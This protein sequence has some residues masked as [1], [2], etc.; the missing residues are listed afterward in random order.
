MS[1]SNVIDEKS[2]GTD[3]ENLNIKSQD[4]DT[5]QKRKRE[6]V[7]SVSSVLDSSSVS[8]KE[9]ENRDSKGRKSKKT[10]KRKRTSRQEDI[11]TN[12]KTT[13]M[14]SK[15]GDIQQ[16]VNKIFI[17]ITEINKKLANVVTKDDGSLREIIKDVFSQMKEEFLKSISYRIDILEGKI[18]DKES[19]NDKLRGEIDRL[20]TQLKEQQ[21][22]NDSMRSTVERSE[23]R[24]NERMNDLEQYSRINNIR[25]DGVDENN[26]EKATETEEKVVNVLNEMMPDLNL[27]TEEIEIAH[28]LGKSKKGKPRQIIV[29]FSSRSTKV[30]ILKRR[31]MLKGSSIYVNEDLTRVN[32]EVLSCVRKKQRD[33]ISSV[34]SRDGKIFYKN[35]MGSIHKVHFRDYSHWLG[36]PW[37]VNEEQETTDEKNTVLNDES[38]LEQ[39]KTLIK[40][41]N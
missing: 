26:G 20:K 24:I 8:L 41:D 9:E 6:T 7:S 14:A 4:L 15:D 3:I 37:P 23:D 5:D 19:E 38:E 2:G 17:Q 30:E 18:F 1:K 39:T 11:N 25:I 33:E 22:E 28:R 40:Q 32:Q 29:Q 10:K 21:E 35:K 13:T 34:W 31:K 12:I 16:N 27:K 36:L